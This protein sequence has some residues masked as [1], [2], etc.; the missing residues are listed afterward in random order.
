MRVSD[1]NLLNK[2]LFFIHL[3]ILFACAEA[4]YAQT[5]TLSDKIEL[6]LTPTENAKTV[7]FI[8]KGDTVYV[9][10]NTTSWIYLDYK[11]KKYYTKYDNI[12]SNYKLDSGYVS[13]NSNDTSCDYGLP[14]SG[15]SIYFER[16][17]ANFRHSTF[18]GYLFGN[19]EE[20][21]C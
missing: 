3:I 19:H 16:P 6:K 20:Y 11:G 12:Y 14:Y 15:S 21:P 9:I 5:I 17:L 1:S 4:A 7:F 8:P 18:L 13:L 10:N 2:I